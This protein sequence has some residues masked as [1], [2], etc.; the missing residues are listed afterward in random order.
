MITDKDPKYTIRFEKQFSKVFT[1]N[2]KN[3]KALTKALEKAISNLRMDPFYASLKTHKVDVID[4]KEVFSSR[5][6]GDWRL[7]WNF[8]Q[9]NNM[10]IICLKLGTHGGGNKVYLKKSN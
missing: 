10:I 7:I 3:D 6:A 2:F 4:E 8:D 9:D 1:K 5:V